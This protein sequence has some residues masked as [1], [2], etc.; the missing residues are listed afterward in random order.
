MLKID[1][2]MPRFYKPTNYTRSWDTDSVRLCVSH[3]M[4]L[5]NTVRACIS[6]THL[7]G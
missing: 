2:G 5:T 3:I 6:Y 7:W 4:V 1:R